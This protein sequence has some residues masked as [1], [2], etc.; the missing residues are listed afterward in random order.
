MLSQSCSVAAGPF[1]PCAPHT[2][3]PLG[4][5]DKRLVSLGGRSHGQLPETSAQ[6][7]QGHGYVEVEMRVHAQDHLGYG[8]LALR[9]GRR[10]VGPSHLVVD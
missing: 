10:H 6:L 4:P 8:V 2:T 3:E 5:R 9:F 7:I 1:K